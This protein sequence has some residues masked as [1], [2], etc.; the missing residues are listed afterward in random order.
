LSF[1]L[2]DHY[3]A[4]VNGYDARFAKYSLGMLCCYL[5]MKESI[6]RGAREA[7]LLWGRNPY[8]FKL[9]GVPRDMANV[10]IYRSRMAYYRHVDRVLRHALR[11]FV[12]KQKSMLLE[13]EQHG[14]AA[15]TIAAR[16]AKTVRNIKRSIARPQH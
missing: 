9:L 7:H 2:G 16:L 5:A 12:D 3:F 8:K 6:G 11:D 1:S 4:Y 14:G 13:G 15:T 10:D